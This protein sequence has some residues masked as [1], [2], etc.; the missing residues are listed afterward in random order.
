[1]KRFIFIPIVIISIGL[2]ILYAANQSKYQ[3]TPIIIERATLENSI[4]SMSAQKLQNPGKIFIRGIHLFVIEQ[5]YG[6][7]IFDN[8][9]PSNPVSLGFIRI[10]GCTDVTVQGKIMYAASAVDMVTLDISD[11]LAVKELR[12]ERNILPEITSQYG[13]IPERYTSQNRPKGTIIIAWKKK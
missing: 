9:N 2:S 5:F 12:R 3:Y 4:A 13:D 8:S 6:V 7:H 1:M 11:F 10:L